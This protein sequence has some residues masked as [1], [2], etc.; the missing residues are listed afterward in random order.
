MDFP[1]CRSHSHVAIPPLD[2]QAPSIAAFRGDLQA[3]AALK[4]DKKGKE[5]KPPHM[6]SQ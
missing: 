6:V 3:Q 2:M 4:E 5:E 1:G